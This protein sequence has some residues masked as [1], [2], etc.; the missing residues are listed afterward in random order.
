M[1]TQNPIQT[2]FNPEI[3]PT[4]KGVSFD[5]LANSFNN[6]QEF[7][8]QIQQQQQQGIL[9]Q[10]LAKNTSADGQVN[11]AN[12]LQTVQSNPNQ[13]YQGVL[14]NTLSGLLQQSNAAKLK[15]QNDALSFD[16]DLNKTYAE[17][18]KLKQE[19]LNKGLESSEKKFGAINQVFQA[20]A[21][22]GS[23]NN[24]L[25]GLNAAHQAG[26]ID[27]DTFNQQR[28]IIDVMS[29]EDIKSFAS[30]ISFGNAKDPASL[31]YQS[32]DNAADNATKSNIANNQLAFDQSSHADDLQ[33]KYDNLEND[34]NQFWANFKQKDA[35]FY[36]AQD[37]E[38]MKLQ[39][40]Q[41]KTANE[42]PEKRMERMNN[43][44]GY[45][46][47][48]NQ[49]ARAAVDAAG[50]INHPG[51]KWGTGVTSLTGMIPSTDARDF[52]ARVENLKSQVFLPTVKAL[53]GMGALSNAEGEK[54][55]SAVANLDPKLGEVAMAKQLTI[56]SQEMNKAAQKAKKQ[57]M[58][59]ASRGGT[60]PLNVQKKQAVPQIAQGELSKAAQQ[61][62]MTEQQVM[63][64]LSQ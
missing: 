58:L 12:A 24:V 2:Y 43:A 10:L 30:G 13:K 33:F 18:G 52:Q 23:K 25:L 40:Q 49:A 5:E 45:A 64:L 26:L 16:A 34:S 55:A 15:A 51:I 53:Q 27:A 31:L 14:V 42:T 63:Q 19:G 29:P 8:N 21:L 28:Q 61:L 50:L 47:A 32:A 4:Y 9:S 62:G 36:S 6:G 17:T 39:I 57:T 48:A 11:L 1:A 38:Q 41:Q 37:L 44:V 35:Q 56:L 54:I 3:A 22:T 60:I 7:S 46:D 59:Y 20:A